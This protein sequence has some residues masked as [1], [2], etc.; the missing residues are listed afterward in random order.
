MNSDRSTRKGFSRRAGW[1]PW[2]L[3]V[4]GVATYSN[5]LDGPFIFD[6]GHAIAEN[7]SIRHV[8]PPQKA[9]FAAA[10]P[11]KGRPVMNLSLA[12]NYAIGGLNVRSYH[13]FN[14]AVHILCA[15]VL[16]GIIRRTLL[17]ERLRD[18]FGDVSRGLALACALIWMVHPL[19][20]ECVNY[21]TQRSES[22]VGLF[23][24]LT[25]YGAIRAVDGH[26]RRGW[27]IASVFSCALGMASKEVMVTAPVTVLL[28]DG[29]FMFGS[30]KEA[31]RRRWSL[32][33]GL[34]STWMVLAALRVAFPQPE[35]QGFH[36][37]VGPLQYAMHQCI[38]IVNYLKL[39]FWPHP[40][41]L[42]Y[43]GIR[44]LSLAEVL[45]YLGILVFLGI[46]TIVLFVY[47][48]M[49]GFLSAWLFVI[50]APT[51]TFV[52]IITE[53]GAERR[54]Y[55]SLAGLVVLVVIAGYVFVEAKWFG[56]HEPAATR[57]MVR[58]SPRWVG[59]LLVTVS[60]ALLGGTTMRRNAEYRTAVS[61]WQTGVEAAPDNPRAHFNLAVAFEH[62]NRLGEA[63]THYRRAVQIE[64]GYA[65]AHD[66]L[67]VLLGSQGKLDEAI[68]H[69]RRAVLANPKY[70]AAYNNLATAL[71][72]QG[73]FE[74]AARY[75]RLVLQ[76]QPDCAEAHNN[77]G[78]AL[79]SQGKLDGVIDHYRRALEIKPGYAEAHNNLGVALRMTGRLEEA[80]VCFREALRLRPDY[81]DALGN[82]AWSLATHPDPKV[83]DPEQVVGMVERVF[84]SGG[85][86]S[87]KCLDALAAAYAAV[88]QFDR[89]VNTA[90]QAI[91]LASAAQ[92]NKLADQIRSRLELY[93]QGKPYR[94][95]LDG[96][97]T[98][99]P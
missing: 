26:H 92:A 55:L 35:S 47:R 58:R 1:A 15:L 61:I 68:D 53:V 28:Y 32:Y 86:P 16:F 38:V 56:V 8:W 24:L 14:I 46:V 95:V 11:T 40:L 29:V 63:V 69:F 80:I 76:I 23:Y 45:P 82:L 89:A 54:M 72:A 5:N 94:E 18:R 90:Q 39:A 81:P 3:I 42:D 6:D 7:Q 50:L 31:L 98:T 30:I 62:Q 25:L 70:V 85:T 21:I 77:L 4:V 2:L 66:N 91:A 97:G 27:R 78:V 83:R 71:L 34:A 48:S 84:Q 79:S 36:L 20:T 43:G 12:M 41:V 60:T 75:L 9:L 96:R 17:S 99:P 65:E 73:N 13:I 37:G 49:I 19:Q 64:P 87:L 52:P 10:G 67:G 59:I 33:V 74:E 93:R 88:G 22:I 57:P 51:S 44:P